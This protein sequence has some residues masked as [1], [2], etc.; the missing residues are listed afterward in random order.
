MVFWDLRGERAE[1]FRGGERKGRVER[2][3]KRKKGDFS[4]GFFVLY[5]GKTL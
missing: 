1:H 5:V 3:N 4:K 2:E